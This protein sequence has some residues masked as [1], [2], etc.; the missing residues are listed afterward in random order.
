MTST[1]SAS[2]RSRRPPLPRDVPL[3]VSFRHP[4]QQSHQPK[5][6]RKQS[7]QQRLAS[8]AS[9]HNKQ[10]HLAHQGEQ[11]DISHNELAEDDMG[12]QE[13]GG[14]GEQGKL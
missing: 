5:S 13:A 6:Q 9:S 11:I 10:V 3:L 2:V 12:R 7:T 4:L 8:A 14:M 1:R